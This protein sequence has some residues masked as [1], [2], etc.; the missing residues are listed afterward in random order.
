MTKNLWRNNS[1]I[2]AYPTLLVVWWRNWNGPHIL[3]NWKNQPYLVFLFQHSFQMCTCFRILLQC[4]PTT[5]GKIVTPPTCRDHGQCGV[6]WCVHSERRCRY[7]QGRCRYVVSYV[8]WPKKIWEGG[9]WTTTCCRLEG[10][11]KVQSFDEDPHTYL[12]MLLSLLLLMSLLFEGGCHTAWDTIKIRIYKNIVLII[13]LWIFDP[14]SDL[15]RLLKI[16]KL[17]YWY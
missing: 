17:H 13:F 8:W 1:S 15:T 11:T 16:I 2:L 3:T 14:P 7:V 6:H 5:A 4:L 9:V 12:C 10:G